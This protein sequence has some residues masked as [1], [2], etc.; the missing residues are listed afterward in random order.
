MSIKKSRRKQQ[1]LALLVPYVALVL[2]TPFLHTDGVEDD[3]RAGWVALHHCAA[4]PSNLRQATAAAHPHH[5]CLACEWLANTTA[6]P[7]H[8][9]ALLPAAPC[10][11]AFSEQGLSALTGPLHDPSVIRGPPL[12]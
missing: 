6:S 9:L 4:G 1:M 12:T 11:L 8:A 5:A 10:V 2:A 7:S 3:A